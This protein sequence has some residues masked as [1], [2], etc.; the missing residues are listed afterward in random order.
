[1]II[2]RCL[3]EIDQTAFGQKDDVTA[4]SHGVAINLGLDIHNGLSVLL[5]PSHINLN[6]EVTNAV[7]R[8]G[9]AQ[10]TGEMR[11]HEL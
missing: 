6:I 9:S 4:G 7:N 8:L 1:M 5:Q 2:L 10:R 3:P 11:R